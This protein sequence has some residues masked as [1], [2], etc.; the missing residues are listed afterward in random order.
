MSEFPWAADRELTVAQ[1]ARAIRSQFPDIQAEHVAPI[2]SGWD[3]DA[4]AVD[5]RW[6][7]RFPRR[8]D[9]DEKLDKER[10]LA[11]IVAKA[12]S[13]L[14]VKVP[15]MSMHG[16]PCDDFPYRFGGYPLLPGVPADQIPEGQVSPTFIGKG[17]GAVL[18]R[19]HSI[20]AD[21]LA[22]VELAVE[23]DSPADSLAE[24]REVADVLQRRENAEV[25]RCVEWVV[26]TSIPPSPYTGELRFIHNDIATEHV[27]VDSQPGRLVGL[28][29]FGDAAFGDPV[30]DFAS[31]PS[32]LG[33][34]ATEA[35]LDVYAL[36]IDREFRERLGFLSR[37][38]SL[39]WLH[40]VYLVE[41]TWRSTEGGCSARLRAR[42]ERGPHG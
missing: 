24:V 35:A 19:L 4:F 22:N 29:D 10:K 18:T 7:F 41:G 30:H 20:N 21:S 25:R 31:L 2:G 33:W 13:D 42:A 28:L 12:L 39:I 8:R 27:L 36:P 34:E 14:G 3:H 16:E 37:A 23:T 6:V 15:A 9:M 40:D 11:P 32:Q 5:D 38:N 1:A 17:L 26:S